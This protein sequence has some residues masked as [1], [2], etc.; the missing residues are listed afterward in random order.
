M[1]TASAPALIP[2][3]RFAAR[4]EVAELEGAAARVPSASP[5]GSKS[6]G[7]EGK[8]PPLCF[9]LVPVAL[10]AASRAQLLQLSSSSIC[11]ALLIAWNPRFL[12]LLIFALSWQLSAQNTP[13]ATLCPVPP[14]TP[15]DPP[16]RGMPSRGSPREQRS[17]VRSSW[18]KT[19]ICRVLK[20]QG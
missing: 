9:R 5:E 7:E 13:L 11:K 19:P 4:E 3:H 15:S 20:H 1:D 16:S 8:H 14:C 12:G 10:T 2:S 6:N 17:S 18:E